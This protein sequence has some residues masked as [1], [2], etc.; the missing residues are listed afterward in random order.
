M[1]NVHTYTFM[2]VKVDSGEVCLMD[3]DPNV[4]T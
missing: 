4:I 3:Y 1:K 2:E